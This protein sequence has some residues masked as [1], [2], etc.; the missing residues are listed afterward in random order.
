MAR[1]LARGYFKTKKKK[2]ESKNECDVKLLQHDEKNLTTIW[3]N[4]FKMLNFGQTSTLAINHK[5]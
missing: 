2:F 3:R 1:V 5:A 4:F